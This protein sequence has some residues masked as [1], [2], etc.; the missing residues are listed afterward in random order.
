M[1]RGYWRRGGLYLGFRVGY[2]I[3]YGVGFFFV[4]RG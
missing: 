3:C 4:G 1:S 2:F